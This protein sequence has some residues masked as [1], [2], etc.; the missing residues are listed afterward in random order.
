MSKLKT[1]IKQ[2]EDLVNVIEKNEVYKSIISEIPESV[3]GLF[4][5]SSQMRY[6]SIYV[7][8]RLNGNTKQ[9]SLDTANR[10][11]VRAVRKSNSLTPIFIE[12]Q[13][14]LLNIHSKLTKGE[15]YQDSEDAEN[16]IDDET[17]DKFYGVPDGTGPHGR[18]AGPDKGKQMV[19]G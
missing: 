17:E 5:A 14:A 4:P 13:K 8:M 12:M 2:F 6:K 7:D 16:A 19:Q 1:V 10:M 9:K 18:G 11:I 3:L 15:F